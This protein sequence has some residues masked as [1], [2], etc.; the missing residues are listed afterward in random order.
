MQASSLGAYPNYF[1]QGDGTICV[2]IHYTMFNSQITSF[3]LWMSIV[4]FDKFALT[5]NFINDE[6][7]FYSLL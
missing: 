6:Q 4:G 3:D 1:G 2:P 5:I 7:V